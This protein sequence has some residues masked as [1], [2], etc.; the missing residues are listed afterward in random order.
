[1]PVETTFKEIHGAFL[2]VVWAVGRFLQLWHSPGY[3]CQRIVNRTLLI[4]PPKGGA[5]P[6]GDT[7]FR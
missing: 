2:S 7:L 3:V 5:I 4:P 6:L 1:M